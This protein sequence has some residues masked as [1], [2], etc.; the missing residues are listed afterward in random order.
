[1]SARGLGIFEHETALG[2]APAHQLFDLLK[3]TGPEVPR[4]FTD[5]QVRGPEKLPP[6]VKFHWAVAPN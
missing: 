3:V 6:G 1:M 2:N 4:S 5:Y